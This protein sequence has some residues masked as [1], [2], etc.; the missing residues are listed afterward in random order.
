MGKKKK[1][2]NPHA[3]SAYESILQK[4]L[5]FLDVF[6]LYSISISFFFQIDT[7]VYAETRKART[8]ELLKFTKLRSCRFPH[9][10][11]QADLGGVFWMTQMRHIQQ[12]L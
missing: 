12:G 8:M 11:I 10:S 1:Y 9:G 5:F 2:A 7:E 4:E 3:L 6:L